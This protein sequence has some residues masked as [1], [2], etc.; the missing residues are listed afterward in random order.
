MGEGWLLSVQVGTP[1]SRGEEGATDPERRPWTSA[2]FKDPVAGPLWLGSTNLDGDRQAD[3]KAHGGP[4]KAV[5]VYAVEHYGRWRAELGIDDLPYGAF[6]ENFTT[7]GLLES[8]VCI[9]DVYEVGDA[10]VQV[11]QPRG[12]CWKIARRWGV[13]DLA[14]RVRA[15]GLTGWYLRVLAEGRVAPGVAIRLVDRPCP[16]WTIAR[17]NAALLGTPPDPE[18]VRALAAC[19]YLSKAWQKSLLHRIEPRTE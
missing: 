19:P 3:L 17:A 18:T 13:P 12:P 2:I 15:A 8:D 5:N 16:E 11:S 6:G 10:T 4:D 1:Q 14:D 9:G 7:E